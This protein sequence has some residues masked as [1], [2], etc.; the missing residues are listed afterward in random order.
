MPKKSNQPSFIRCFGEVR[1]IGDYSNYTILFVAEDSITKEK[2]EYGGLNPINST[3]VNTDSTVQ[4]DF[5]FTFGL[6][7]NAARLS[8]YIFNPGGGKIEGTFHVEQY[9]IDFD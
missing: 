7:P 6:Y 8:S 1:N 4:F 3:K 2:Y 9:V 5:T